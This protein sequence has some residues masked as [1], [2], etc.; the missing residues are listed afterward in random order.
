MKVMGVK[1]AMNINAPQL[2]CLIL[3][4][5]KIPAPTTNSAKDCK[6]DNKSEKD[7]AQGALNATK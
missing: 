3:R 2:L 6:I 4:F 1:I 7:E 5:S